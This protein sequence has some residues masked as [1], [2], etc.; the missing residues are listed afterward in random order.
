MLPFSDFFIQFK[1]KCIGPNVY[2]N[3]WPKFLSKVTVQKGGGKETS[4]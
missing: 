4:I 3:K 1:I 2:Y